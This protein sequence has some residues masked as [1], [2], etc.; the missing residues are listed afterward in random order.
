[1][2]AFNMIPALPL[3]GGRVL[4]A[5][6][7]R[8]RGNL[9]WA[10]RVASRVSQALAVVLIVLGLTS[11][12]V[13]AALVGLWLVLIGWF[14]L[15]GAA[16]QR[17]AAEA[18]IALAGVQVGDA[19]TANPITV[20]SSAA[21]DELIDMRRRTGHSVYPVVDDYGDAI[22]LVSARSARLV[23]ERRRQWVTAR[24]LLS[25]APAPLAIDA[26]TDLISAVPALVED[27]RHS[28][29]VLR[30]GHLVGVLSLSDV[31]RAVRLRS[32]E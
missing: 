10:T 6:L 22:G 3:D 19:M 11:V 13:S 17:G 32:T 12:L 27:P 25:Q 23:P 21:A 20:P 26:G 29:A 24:E 8:L 15:S 31:S 14:I 4:R 5:I 2:L 28:A 7:W 1:L 18:Q 30:A 9:I 16:A